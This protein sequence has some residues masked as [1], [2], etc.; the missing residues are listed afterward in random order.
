V[1]SLDL[2]MIM[3][4]ISLEQFIIARRV[5]FPKSESGVRFYLSH[6]LAV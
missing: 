2:M 4:S 1:K 3:V 6:E 5:F